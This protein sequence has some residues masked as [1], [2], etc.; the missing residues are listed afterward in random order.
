MSKYVIQNDLSGGVFAREGSVD[1]IYSP[2]HYLKTLWDH[3]VTLHPVDDDYN[4]KKRLPSFEKIILSQENMDS[5]VSLLSLVNDS[6]ISLCQSSDGVNAVS[7]RDAFM[8]QLSNEKE[9]GYYNV[10]LNS[11][12]YLL[13]GLSEDSFPDIETAVENQIYSGVGYLPNVEIDIKR[14]HIW[15]LTELYGVKKEQ[16]KVM[17]GDSISVNSEIDE[18]TGDEIPSQI[19]RLFSVN[20]NQLP[21]FAS[22]DDFKN[23]LM[24]AFNVNGTELNLLTSLSEKTLSKDM[25]L[26]DVSK[27]YSWVLMART[28]GCKI[29]ELVVLKAIAPANYEYLR[30]KM[31]KDVLDWLDDNKLTVPGLLLLTE[32]LPSD[33][34]PAM[35]NLLEELTREAKSLNGLKKTMVA[36]A[37]TSVFGLASPSL[38]L[39]MMDWMDT[40]ILEDNAKSDG[41]ISSVSSRKKIQYILFKVPTEFYSNI[42][43]VKVISNGENILTNVSYS[44]TKT[45]NSEGVT[46]IEKIVDGDIYTSF[47]FATNEAGDAAWLQIDLGNAYPVENIS[48]TVDYGSSNSGA[49]TLMAGVLFVSDQDMSTFAETLNPDDD[50][51]SNVDY[52]GVV[53]VEQKSMPVTQSFDLTNKKEQGIYLTRLFQRS[54]AINA[55]GLTSNIVDALSKTKDTFEYKE[56]GKDNVILSM[57]RLRVLSRLKTFTDSCGNNAPDFLKQFADA[58]LTVLNISQYLSINAEYLTNFDQK[59]SVNFN[60]A[61]VIYEKYLFS[62][63]TGVS[64]SNLD[65]LSTIASDASYDDWVK[66]ANAM[67]PEV[68]VDR[69]NILQQN[70]NSELRN[71]LSML[72][73]SRKIPAYMTVD[74]ISSYLLTDINTSAQTQ[75]SKVSW[76]ISC[77][78]LY[79]DRCLTG[80]EVNIVSPAIGS[81]CA[82]FLANWD[83]Y[84]KRYSQWAALAELL[85]EPEN[86]LDPSLRLTQSESFKNLLQLLNG[87]SINQDSAEEAFTSYLTDFEKM[88]EIV[89]VNAFHDNSSEDIGKTW[90]IGYSKESPTEWYWRSVDHACLSN[91]TAPIRAWTTWKKIDVPLMP[92]KGGAS[93]LARPVLYHNRLNV[94]W[95]E[96]RKS[97]VPDANQSTKPVTKTDYIIKLT[98]QRHDGSWTT[99]VESVLQ[100]DNAQ[101]M[102]LTIDP[103]TEDMVIFFDNAWYIL[104]SSAV[105]KSTTITYTSSSQIS[106]ENKIPVLF[107]ATQ[108]EFLTGKVTSVDKIQNVSPFD[109]QGLSFVRGSYY[110]STDNTT[111]LSIV[112]HSSFNDSYINLS[113]KMGN[114]NSATFSISSLPE[115]FFAFKDEEVTLTGI[116]L[117]Q[118]DAPSAINI[119]N[120]KDKPERWSL[121]WGGNNIALSSEYPTKL[122]ELMSQGVDAVFSMNDLRKQ[123]DINQLLD[124]NGALGVYYWELFYHVPL[125]I[126]LRLKDMQEYE[127]ANRW[128]S[129]IFTPYKQDANYWKSLPL[130]PIDTTWTV[131]PNNTDP[132]AVAVTHPRHYRLATAM[133]LLDLLIARGDT[134]YRQ[135]E[136]DTLVE[137]QMWYMRALSIL[138]DRD[139]HLEI[140]SD[141]LGMLKDLS[142]NDFKAQENKKLYGYWQL[143]TQRLYNLR[144]NLTLDGQALNLPLFAT[145]GN[146][147]GLLSAAQS[148]DSDLSLLNHN[149]SVGLLRFKPALELARG[150]A[151]QLVQFGSSLQGIAERQDAEAMSIL[152]QTQGRQLMSISCDI[153]N[154]AVAA[155]DADLAALQIRYDGITQRVTYYQNLYDENISPNEQSALGL[156]ATASALLVSGGVANVAAGALD[157]ALPNVYGL[158]DGGNRW[159]SVLNGVGALLSNTAFSLTNIAGSL[160]QLDNYRRRRDEWKLEIGSANNQLAELDKQ[161]AALQARREAASKQRTYLFTQQSQLSDQLQFLKSKF[162]NQQ[163]YG[164]MKS[165][166]SMIFWQFYDIAINSSLRAEK[167]FIFETGMLTQTFIRPGAWQNAASGLLCGESLLLDLAQMEQAWLSGSMR[168]LEVVRTVSVADLLKGNADGSTIAGLPSAIKELMKD[169]PSTIS[170]QWKNNNLNHQLTL[171]NSTLEC[172]ISLSA[173]NIPADYPTSLGLGSKRK[174]KNINVSLPALVGPYQ[175]IQAVLSYKDDTFS[176]PPGCGSIAV[177]HGIN[178]SGQFQL[179]FNDQRYLPFEGVMLKGPDDFDNTGFLLLQ[180]PNAT[181]SQKK[182][183]SSLNDIILHIHYTIQD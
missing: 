122:L 50:A 15:Q 123:S 9:S 157:T 77:L 6:L 90:F 101:D 31:F 41:F 138:G 105:T 95:V 53:K 111:F 144:N 25:K 1:S 61:A 132:D 171:N 179:D 172:E 152:L 10:A 177:S 102:Q 21:V 59:N 180:F 164:W 62:Q 154:N 96:S 113:G 89:T 4:I 110:T 121:S 80:E 38:A 81:E 45:N 136:R 43:E 140:T 135:L 153:Q 93:L 83:A 74:D 16:A 73:I 87:G 142:A 159:G 14:S 19:N 124:F 82:N 141:G 108:S 79:I 52:L 160:T 137:A 145:L 32:S 70:L 165:R 54:L 76:A 98:Y 66:V 163:L 91:N 8:S 167:A 84:N 97:Q 68:P 107:P 46:D 133:R 13:K 5:E 112:L 18:S 22:E 106:S 174:I 55:L 64:L 162:A 3:A 37:I 85:T 7:S 42:Y 166:I 127:L 151:G 117:H 29:S 118:S 175:S 34:T 20:N 183:L 176:S 100:G 99:P 182:F 78:Q 33:L 156:N 130:L 58:T 94:A 173:L 88:T 17:C 119:I 114:N 147:A 51:H 168:A 36:E 44:N 131:Y 39:A 60:Q 72:L 71:A 24:K 104:D 143:L 28:L 126:S 129:Y 161:R 27:L 125:L 63:R 75:A 12:R 169:S 103:H 155:L 26:D 48:L 30:Y 47:A 67:M 11:I 170:F 40:D 65:S 109:F 158:A 178:D 148:A 35:E 56:N 149:D 57:E 146:P 116:T 69:L 23:G 115:S 139:V 120:T 86:Y 49:P 150:L 92:L 2:G 181:A 128:I 134:A